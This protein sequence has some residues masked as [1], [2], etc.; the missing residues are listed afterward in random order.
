M[1][2]NR[3]DHAFT[4]H[5]H[6]RAAEKLALRLYGFT[7]AIWPEP[8]FE[9]PQHFAVEELFEFS[10]HA[11]RASELAGLLDLRID[12]KPVSTQLYNINGLES[13]DW[14]FDYHYALN[15]IRHN[16][17]FKFGKSNPPINS[18][19]FTHEKNVMAGFLVVATERFPSEVA[20]PFFPLLYYF[21]QE[22][23]PKISAYKKS[24]DEVHQ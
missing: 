20:I 23:R 22:I 24:L 17:S 18:K 1:Q 3:K 19:L 8:W 12:M 13:F 4:F 9:L 15:R 14:L 11:Y 2:S 10:F 16:T 21:L 6:S 5:V 7:R